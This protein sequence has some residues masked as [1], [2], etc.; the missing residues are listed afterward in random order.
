[1]I[2][3]DTTNQIRW[4]PTSEIPSTIPADKVNVDY[5]MTTLVGRSSYESVQLTI[6][7]FW[8]EGF[9][10]IRGCAIVSKSELLRRYGGGFLFWRWVELTR[11]VYIEAFHRNDDLL[12]RFRL[13]TDF[14]FIWTVGAVGWVIDKKRDCRS[15]Q[16]VYEQLW[17]GFWRIIHEMQSKVVKSE[18]FNC[19]TRKLN[20]HCK[21]IKFTDLQWT[22]WYNLPINTTDHP[23][24]WGRKSCHFTPQKHRY[25]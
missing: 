11:L 13:L 8:G 24:E 10:F 23:S 22:V 4:S 15:Q 14:F 12:L 1:M 25:I 19:I 21:T 17:N 7:A 20:L 2:A 16:I 5:K 6:I 18:L 9:F 3:A